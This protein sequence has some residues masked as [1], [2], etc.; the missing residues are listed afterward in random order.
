MEKYPFRILLVK[1]DGTYQGRI[2]YQ[3]D[4]PPLGFSFRNQRDE[5]KHVCV[6][7]CECFEFAVN[8]N[9]GTLFLRGSFSNADHTRTRI[10]NTDCYVKDLAISLNKSIKELYSYD[11]NL[12][13]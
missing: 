12:S 5:L 4:M 10:F 6:S 3:E 8:N 9:G 13:I 7:S 2:V 1:I 11:E